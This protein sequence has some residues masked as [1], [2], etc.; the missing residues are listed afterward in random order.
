[1]PEKLFNFSAIFLF[2]FFRICNESFVHKNRLI[3][4]MTK[5]HVKCEMPYCCQVPI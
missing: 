5:E 1:M 2:L 4:H 3:Y